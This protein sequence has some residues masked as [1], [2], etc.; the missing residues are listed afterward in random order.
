MIDTM[1]VFQMQIF[2]DFLK[3]E[4]KCPNVIPH[5][6]VF[7]AKGLVVLVT[8]CVPFVVLNK[9]NYPVSRDL[10]YMSPQKS[11]VAREI[12]AHRVLPDI[13]L[14]LFSPF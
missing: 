6:H 5:D 14:L 10:S 13:I 3:H 1:L 7:K 8:C 4:K 11:R 12:S 9:H 2:L